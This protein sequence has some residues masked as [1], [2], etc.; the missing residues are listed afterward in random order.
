MEG[1]K[2]EQVAAV[3]ALIFRNPNTKENHQIMMVTR[4]WFINRPP[5]HLNISEL[6][7][8]HCYIWPPSKIK[9][10]NKKEIFKSLKGLVK[11]KKSHCRAQ[12]EAINLY[13]G[14]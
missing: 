9:L 6:Y 10:I 13:S 4:K 8:L 2:E 3:E 7:F 5:S 1:V 12:F 11:K 14:A